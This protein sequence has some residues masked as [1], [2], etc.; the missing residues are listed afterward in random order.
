[1]GH[2]AKKR[3]HPGTTTVQIE[4]AGREGRM[5]VEEVPALGQESVLNPILLPTQG[6][7]AGLYI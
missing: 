4:G 6:T 5:V 1:M 7:Y 2:K 3:D